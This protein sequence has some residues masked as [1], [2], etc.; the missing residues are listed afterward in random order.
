MFI[1][2]SLLLER[3]QVNPDNVTLNFDSV[4]E[5]M[6]EP[7]MKTIF[8]YLLSRDK[9]KTLIVRQVFNFLESVRF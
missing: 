2:L 7:Y 1:T 6:K 9:L 8:T 4:V 3:H 5:K